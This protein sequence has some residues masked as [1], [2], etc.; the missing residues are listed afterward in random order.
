MNLL[1][2]LSKEV[3]CDDK[4]DI[5]DGNNNVT[6]TLVLVSKLLNRN[7]CDRNDNKEERVNEHSI[8][9]YINEPVLINFLSKC[10]DDE[11]TWNLMNQGPIN[12]ENS[13]NINAPGKDDVISD[14]LSCHRMA[15]VVVDRRASRTGLSSDQHCVRAGSTQRS[16]SDEQLAHSYS[17]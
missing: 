2:N 6:T 16:I 11:Y 9:S 7:E 13:I 4:N 8:N 14:I 1:L 3:C 10:T 17:L 5:E 12:D 15:S